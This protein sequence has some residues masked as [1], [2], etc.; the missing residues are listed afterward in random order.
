MI[1]LVVG[2]DD[3]GR[4]D[5]AEMVLQSYK[6]I[7][8]KS[9]LLKAADFLP[10]F[11][12]ERSLA[13]LS[14][15]RDT[16]IAKLEKSLVSLLKSGGNIV[17]SS[18]LSRSTKHGYLPVITE[19]FIEAIKPDAL[20]L[21]EVVPRRVESYMEHEHIDWM[22]QRVERHMASIFCARSGAPLKIIKVRHW[23]VSEALKDVAEAL[24]A[25]M[26]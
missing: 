10:D 1:I 14:R 24:R 18:S 22:H 17:L 9:T 15:M 2:I 19:G 12:P 20:I 8:P 4:D 21:L 16:G 13:R 26:E 5:I 11:S 7:M 3:S 6:K 23:K 25:A